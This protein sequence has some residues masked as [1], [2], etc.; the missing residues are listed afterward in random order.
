MHSDFGKDLFDLFEI[1]RLLLLKML[2]LEGSDTRLYSE[3]P[4]PSMG[5]A[6]NDPKAKVLNAERDS[7]AKSFFDKVYSNDKRICS[8]SD[9]SFAKTDTYS[10]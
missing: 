10:H 9:L 1:S 2:L 6:L 5:L 4:I 3:I 8:Y 7:I